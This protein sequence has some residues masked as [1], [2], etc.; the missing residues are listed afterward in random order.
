MEL[1]MDNGGMLRLRPFLSSEQILCQ[2]LFHEAGSIENK[3]ILCVY[4]TPAA[5]QSS[6]DG[7]EGTH[8]MNT[9]DKNDPCLVQ[10]I[11]HFELQA[12]FTEAI[13]HEC[14]TVVICLHFEGVSGVRFRFAI[15]YRN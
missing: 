3:A 13:E 4:D 9:F 11:E 7:K 2:R 5:Y 1:R 6:L 14:Y 15:N 8:S 10:T 12:I